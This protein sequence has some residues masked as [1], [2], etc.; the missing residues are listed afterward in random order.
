MDP[1]K[2]PQRHFG[3]VFVAVCARLFY[4]VFM[5]LGL[6]IPLQRYLR[7]A[8]PP[9]PAEHRFFFCWDLHVLKP[10]GK[11]GLFAVHASSRYGF[12]L[13]APSHAQ[14]GNLAELFAQGLRGSLEAE[15]LTHAQ[16]NAFFEMADVPL[17]TK[18]H[19]RRPVV[20]LNRAVDDFYA[21]P[22]GLNDGSL[23]QPQITRALNELVC[24]AA[25]H[26]GYGT[27]RAFLRRELAAWGIL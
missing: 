21:L 24:H 14:W 19:G 25:G 17:F 10:K 26:E 12:F 2:K 5:E 8:K 3:R 13:H 1:P 11:A 9:Y 20:F 22:V 4:G 27:P 23:A 16:A 18:T 7:R 6:T 15:G